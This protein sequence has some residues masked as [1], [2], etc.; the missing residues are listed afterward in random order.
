MGWEGG[1][2]D[3]VLLKQIENTRVELAELNSQK[4]Q[5]QPVQPMDYRLV[6]DFLAGLPEKWYTY[7]RT[8]R[9]R[10]LKPLIDHVD[11]R[12]EW[13][14]VEATIHWK[15]GQSQ[16]IN[17]RRARAKG[18]MESL[19]TEEEK[20]LLKMLWPSASQDAI[21]SALPGRTWSAIAHKAQSNGWKRTP[22]VYSYVPRCRWLQD[23]ELRAKQDYE[24]GVSLDKIAEDLKRSRGAILQ[25][26][27]EKGWTRPHKAV[28]ERAKCFFSAKQ[29]ST[30][31][32][33]ISS[34]RGSGG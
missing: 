20:G 30:V 8:L 26:A 5:T 33:S 21:R 31:T 2:H 19:W 7:S 1:Q 34:G 3:Q 29:N 13:P 32:K 6:K 22:T 11:I 23:E 27:S 16:V 24:A 25:R 14:V 28:G 18:N 4:L 12:H 15:T 9:N 17:I 10:L